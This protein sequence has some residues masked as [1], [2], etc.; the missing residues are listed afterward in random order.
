V[1]IDSL[2]RYRRALGDFVCGLPAWLAA[3]TS[4][5]GPPLRAVD[6]GRV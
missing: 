3:V 2:R 6:G 1:S 5:D 4:E